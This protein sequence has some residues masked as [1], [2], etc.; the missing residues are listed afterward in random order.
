MGHPEQR[1]LLRTLGERA[2][3]LNE[4]LENIDYGRD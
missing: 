1:A 2:T 4:S 3:F